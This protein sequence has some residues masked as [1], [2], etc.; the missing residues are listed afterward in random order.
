MTDLRDII[1]GCQKGKRSAQDKLYTQYSRMLFGV[2]LRY[3][4]TREEAEDVMQE[5]FV[6]IYN[7]IKSYS[8]EGSFEAWMRRIMINTAITG[9][10]KNK[11]HMYQQDI[12]EPANMEYFKTP[13]DTADFNREELMGAI[14]KLPPGYK[15]VFN[16]YV[17][18]GYKHKE[19]ADELGININTSKSQLSR[20]KQH[21]QNYLNEISEVKVKYDE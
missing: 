13:D 6:K 4:N 1:L 8:M 11:K 21:L 14:E 3:T 19:I 12:N 5:G 7:H 17:I 10:R 2:C 18:E 9:Y 15:I 16:M 20:A